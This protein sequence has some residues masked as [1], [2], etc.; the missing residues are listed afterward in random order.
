MRVDNIHIKI[1]VRMY[2]FKKLIITSNFGLA[3]VKNKESKK[4]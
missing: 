1:L 4:N 3:L 2:L